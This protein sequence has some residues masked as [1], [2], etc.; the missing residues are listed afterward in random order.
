M[1]NSDKDF[2]FVFI[3]QDMGYPNIPNYNPEGK[4]IH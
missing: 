1:G 4:I 3:S 2:F